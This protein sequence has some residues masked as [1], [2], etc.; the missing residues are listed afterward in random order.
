[1]GDTGDTD[2]T[3]SAA[4]AYRELAD[5]LRELASTVSSGK[6]LTLVEA[7]VPVPVATVPTVEQSSVVELLRAGIRGAVEVG[8]CSALIALL[9]VVGFNV[10]VAVAPPARF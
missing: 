2:A 9:L 1:M 8:T 7:P 10:W 5:G 3:P 4:T 6:P